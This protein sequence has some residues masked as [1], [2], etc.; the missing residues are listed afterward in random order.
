VVDADKAFG[1]PFEAYPRDV[2][3]QLR[4]IRVMGVRRGMTHAD[5][6][7]QLAQREVHPFSLHRVEPPA[8]RPALLR[9]GR[10]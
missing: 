5:A 9:H 6:S 7:R 1:Q 4:L 2:G 3:E 10:R 8:A